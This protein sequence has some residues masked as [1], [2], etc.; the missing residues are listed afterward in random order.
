MK[1]INLN[2]KN[3]KI[4]FVCIFIFVIVGVIYNERKKYIFGTN[5]PETFIVNDNE[6]YEIIHGEANWL[7]APPGEKFLGGNSYLID[8]NKEFKENCSFIEM[9]SGSELSFHI[10]YEDLIKNVTLASVDVTDASTPKKIEYKLDAPYIFKTPT[11]KGD[12]YY[13]LNVKWDVNHNVD[14]LFKIKII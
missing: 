6:K 3:K 12:Y 9:K 4:I 11:E 10:K 8:T 14:Y 1:K 5:I 7:L 13:I 2:A